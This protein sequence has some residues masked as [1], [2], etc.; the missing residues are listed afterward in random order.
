MDK[1]LEIFKI[2]I[3]TPNKWRG[4]MCFLCFLAIIIGAYLT[5]NNLI[6]KPINIDSDVKI[7]KIK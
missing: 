7:Q 3:H 6:N 2:C 5:I 1:F 4:R